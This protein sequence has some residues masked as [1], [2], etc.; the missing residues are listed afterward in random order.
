MPNKKSKKSTG[1]VPEETVTTA[2]EEVTASEVVAETPE[3][4]ENQTSDMSEVSG[5][6]PVSQHANL[7]L[8]DEKV[9][10]ERSASY[11]RIGEVT[12]HQLPVYEGLGLRFGEGIASYMECMAPN[13]PMTEKK[14]IPYQRGLLNNVL[15][16]FDL[17][18]EDFYKVMNWFH[19]VVG[20]SRQKRT[21]FHDNYA[22]RYLNMVNVK[23]RQMI[24]YRKFMNLVKTTSDIKNR[25]LIKNYVDISAVA[26]SAL[27]SEAGEK[28][29][30][31]YTT[32]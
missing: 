19:R 23:P 25:D 21:A 20:T 11:V 15:N 8:D 17:P 24:F 32:S 4:S 22:S 6:L 2:T 30:H 29:M 18:Y 28:I 13:K 3:L 5:T 16:M 1:L 26:E 9:V 27:S 14:G 7:S 12:E 10:A 31:Y